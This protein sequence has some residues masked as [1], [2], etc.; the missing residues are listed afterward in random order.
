MKSIFTGASVGLL[1]LT[2]LKFPTIPD[3]D[4]PI[5]AGFINM[6]I[7]FA[8]LALVFKSDRKETK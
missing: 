4:F 5:L 1:M 8:I 2:V 3:A 7:C 6:A